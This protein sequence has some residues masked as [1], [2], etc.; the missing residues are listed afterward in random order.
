[1]SVW[2]STNSAHSVAA[3]ACVL[4]AA[5]TLAGCVSHRRPVMTAAVPPVVA[6]EGRQHAVHASSPP[7][8]LSVPPTAASGGSRVA[9]IPA[10]TLLVAADFGRTFRQ[11]GGPY[12]VSAMP[13]PFLGCGLDGLPGNDNLIASV[14][15]G[16][17]EGVDGIG[18]VADESVLRFSTGGAHQTMTAINALL[19]GECAARFQVVSRRL[20]GD[21]S[22]L[23]RSSDLSVALSQYAHGTILY[24]AIVRHGDYL[25]WITLA[26]EFVRTDRTNLAIAAAH[27]SETRLCATIGC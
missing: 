4:A 7:P 16:F 15:A 25:A 18:A 5:L 10:A 3:V 26:D 9:T 17:V 12:P 23:L 27:E 13:N 8:S 21:E 19:N 11:V 1:M 14:G 20:G 2:R 22:V 6:S 24:Y